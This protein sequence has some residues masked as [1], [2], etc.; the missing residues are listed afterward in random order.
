MKF[1]KKSKIEKV[2][3]R[4]LSFRIILT[5]ILLTIVFGFAN[6][7]L[8]LKAGIT[9]AA[10]YPV[11]VL[12]M[13][14]I[15]HFKKSNIL[16][17]NMLRTIGSIGESI[18]GGA[19]F[20][21]PA[22]LITNA[23]DPNFFGSYR[24]YLQ[25]SI[26]LLIGGFLGIL[27]ASLLRKILIDDPN[28]PFPESI[29][30]SEIHKSGRSGK[31]GAKYLFFTMGIGG[32][33]EFLK[34]FNLL[35]AK[36]E[37]FFSFGK[38]TIPGTGFEQFKGIET[39]GGILIKSPALSPAF[40]GIGYIIGPGLA[41][42]NFAGGILAWGLFVPLFVLILAPQY[43][44]IVNDGVMT[45]AEVSKTVFT[46]IVKP[47]AIGGMLT[48]AAYTLWGMRVSILKGLKKSGNE[49]SKKSNNSELKSRDKDVSPLFVFAAIFILSGFVMIFF[50][51]LFSFSYE[52]LVPSIFS[53]LIVIIGGYIFAA[54]SG[55]QVGMIGSSNNPVSGITIFIILITAVF[56]TAIG[57]TGA[58]GMILVLS[59]AGVICVSAAVGGAMFQDLK[60]GYLLGGTPW[61][62]QAG[63]FIGVIIAS[64]VMW[65]PL[66]ILN[67]GDLKMAELNGYQGGFGGDVL[68]AP[69]AGV[70]A[71]LTKGIVGGELVWPLITVGI[72]MGIGFTLVKVKSPMLVCVGMYLSFEVVAAI[73]AGGIIRWIV[74]MIAK[75]RDYSKKEISVIANRGVL[76]ASGLIAGEAMM[77]L[78]FAALAFFDVVVPNLWN[79]S[80]FFLST[81]VIISIGFLLV[82]IPLESVKKGDKDFF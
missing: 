78:M 64:F 39:G 24:G 48:S 6:V 72:I 77:G 1:R 8:G 38:K 45:W 49:I 73:F 23:W 59:V 25:I 65:I 61:K 75:K 74:D 2:K 44:P 14:L 76:L 55:Y 52:G 10:T 54:V 4:E 42:L 36:W 33:I 40:I 22:F 29:A 27:F 35:P 60:I 32:M 13:E 68:A 51:W 80:P 53:A 34:N 26:I 63:D 3:T 28:L 66:F 50:W 30:A 18:A 11:A 69:Q 43:S 41:A 12:G 5:G 79:G 47:I 9:I 17:E 31:T 57:F 16:E 62:M 37:S 82:R 7:Y 58:N 70:M 46:N 56:L 71:Q 15:R 21:I 81:M 67:A 20:T 19:I